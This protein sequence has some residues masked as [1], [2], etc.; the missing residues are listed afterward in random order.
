MS[1][2]SRQEPWV[3]KIGVQLLVLDGHHHLQFETGLHTERLHFGYG[4]SILDIAWRWQGHFCIDF[5][6]N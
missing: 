2:L 3:Q 5:D 4:L 1:F 6:A